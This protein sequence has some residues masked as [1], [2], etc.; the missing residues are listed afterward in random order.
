MFLKPLNEY[1]NIA[2]PSP[3]NVM[4]WHR[5]ADKR[6]LDSLLFSIIHFPASRPVYFV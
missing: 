4:H 6:R 5:Y 3:Q 1:V 2:S